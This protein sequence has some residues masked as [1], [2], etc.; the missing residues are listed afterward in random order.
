MESEIKK[1]LCLKHLNYIKPQISQTQQYTDVNSQFP[2]SK[3]SW[4]TFCPRM[5]KFQNFSILYNTFCWTANA[6]SYLFEYNNQPYTPQFPVYRIENPWGTTHA[7]YIN[8]PHGLPYKEVKNILN[9][10]LYGGQ[11]LT[12]VF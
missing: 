3:L 8:I 1:F 9:T 5:S 7:E 4:F 10:T 12:A 2:I 11:K 6:N